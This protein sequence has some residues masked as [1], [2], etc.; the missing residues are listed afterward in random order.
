MKGMMKT[1]GTIDGKAEEE[2]IPVIEKHDRKV[3]LA[4][5]WTTLFFCCGCCCATGALLALCLFGVKLG[6]AFDAWWEAMGKKLVPGG[7]AMDALAEGDL[8][9]AA[10][11][12]AEEAG[13]NGDGD[14]SMFD[15]SK[16]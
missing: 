15:N 5:F 6:L 9:G 3:I 8:E 7:E 13:V 16:L 1:A 10:A 2:M 14:G 11:N 12:A 4:T